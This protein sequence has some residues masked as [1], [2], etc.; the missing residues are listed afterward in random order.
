M[1]LHL[2]LIGF[3]TSQANVLLSGN[4]ASC[5]LNTPFSGDVRMTSLS[6]DGLQG[7]PEVVIIVTIITM[8]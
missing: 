1:I 8:L 7:I 3:N 2:N 6:N 4:H 5:E